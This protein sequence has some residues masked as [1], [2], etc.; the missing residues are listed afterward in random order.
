MGN[1]RVNLQRR[2]LWPPKKCKSSK[3]TSHGPQIAEQLLGGRKVGA[4]VGQSTSGVHT[5]AQVPMKLLRSILW[6]PSQTFANKGKEWS[7]Q[8]LRF[9]TFSPQFRVFPCVLA[10]VHKALNGE[11]V[12]AALHSM[13][14]VA[15][16]D[17]TSQLAHV[18]L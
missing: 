15:V 16:G 3:K 18:G 4:S 1:S 9:A 11:I 13:R 12:V 14:S 8:V 17:L 7:Y 2:L 6:L 10:L 5:D